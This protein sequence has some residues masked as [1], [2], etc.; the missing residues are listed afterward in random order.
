V[1]AQPKAYGIVNSY[2]VPGQ[3]GSDRW[4]SLVGARQVAASGAV[5]VS[6]GTAVTID[7]LTADGVFSGGLILPGVEAAREILSRKTAGIVVDPLA[8]YEVFP[9]NTTNAVY[10]GALLA[11][12]GAVERM[13][14]AMG[15]PSAGTELILTGG[16]ADL[17]VPLVRPQPRVVPNL[18]LEGLL[19]IAREEG[20]L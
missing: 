11:I 7:A 9:T 20:M 8:H 12:A 1:T 6:V 3:L 13:Y 19:H 18:V 17:V 15:G 5:V 16:G 10:S 14:E 4:A 2:N